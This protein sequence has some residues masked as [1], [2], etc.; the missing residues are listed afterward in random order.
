[1]LSNRVL[2]V[3]TRMCSPIA[4]YRLVPRSFR[5]RTGRRRDGRDEYRTDVLPCTGKAM[6]TDKIMQVQQQAVVVGRRYG[7][8]WQVQCNSIEDRHAF[9]ETP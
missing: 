6:L 7:W 1:M 8:T 9:R 4:P 5:L 2:R 3:T